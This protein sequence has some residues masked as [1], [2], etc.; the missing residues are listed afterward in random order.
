MGCATKRCSGPVSARNCAQDQQQRHTRCVVARLRSRA[1]YAHEYIIS[2][3]YIAVR[4]EAFALAR[5]PNATPSEHAHARQLSVHTVFVCCSIGGQC[6]CVRSRRA[7]C[8]V[9]C[10]FASSI[11]PQPV[12]GHKRPSFAAGIRALV[13]IYRVRVRSCVRVIA[14][15]REVKKQICH[16]LLLVYVSYTSEDPRRWRLKRRGKCAVFWCG[17]CKT[18]S[19]SLSGENASTRILLYIHILLHTYI[20]LLLAQVRLDGFGMQLRHW[21]GIINRFE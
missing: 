8:I 3:L 12:Q 13:A 4:C 9:A 2:P 19:I 7:T 5:T 20:Y 17:F 10:M 16:R 18:R 14:C 11:G 21:D 1:R 15:A 6:V